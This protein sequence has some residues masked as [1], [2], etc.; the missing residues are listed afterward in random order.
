MQRSKAFTLIELLVT[1][2]IIG[3]L[4]GIVVPAMSGARSHALRITCQTRLHEVARAVWEYSVAN[5]S[6]VPYVESP[7]TNRWNTSGGTAE[8]E[9]DPYDRQRWPKSLQNVLMPVYLG[10]D[11]KVFTCPAAIV[12]WPRNGAPYKVTYRD[13]GA[14]QPN[15]IVE[16][17]KNYFRESF[18]FLDGRPMIEMR[19][20]ATGNLLNDAM[21]FGASRGT[22]VR[23]MVKREG[24]RRDSMH[25]IGPHDR[26]INVV[27]REFGVEFRDFE[28]IQKDLAPSGRGVL[29]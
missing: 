10:E 25:V 5:D 4:I 3:A 17:G 22:Y 9:Y 11:P 26:G 6:R 15:G 24:G 8:A 23:D 7:L 29:F 13:A 2:S 19:F 1:I 12:G 27:N 14:N 16:E 21:T 20:R 18:G 28:T